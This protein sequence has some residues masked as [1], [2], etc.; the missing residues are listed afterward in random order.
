MYI[1][2][3]LLIGCFGNICFRPKIATHIQT[4]TRR[5]V[6]YK[7]KTL[8]DSKNQNDQNKPQNKMKSVSQIKKNN[9]LSAND[10]LRNN[11][12]QRYYNLMER[13]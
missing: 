2:F 5:F 6:T 8:L 4:T 1:S 11:I 13:F 10:L 3:F 12:N 9:Q 7:Q